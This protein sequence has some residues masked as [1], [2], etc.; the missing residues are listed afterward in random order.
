MSQEIR[1]TITVEN[2][3][4]LHARPA[5]QLVQAIRNLN[6]RVHLWCTEGE[7]VDGKSILGVMMLAA[8]RGTTVHVRV[9]GPDSA[10]AVAEIARILEDHPP[11]EQN[12]AMGS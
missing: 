3:D 5:A 7:E 10:Q 8:E 2:E 1:T 9:D 11:Q 6:C 12:H 4:G